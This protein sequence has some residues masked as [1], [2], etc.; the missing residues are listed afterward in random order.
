MSIMPS[1]WVI[2]AAAAPFVQAPSEPAPLPV[3]VMLPQLAMQDCDLASRQQVFV[4]RTLMTSD[5]AELKLTYAPSTDQC[6]IE[7]DAAGAAA[8]STLSDILSEDGWERLPTTESRWA[9]VDALWRKNDRLIEVNRWRKTQHED[10][11]SGA[12]F[13]TAADGLSGQQTLSTRKRQ[14]RPLA[15]ALIAAVFDL[16]P[17]LVRGRAAD[18]AELWEIEPEAILNQEVLADPTQ[19]TIDV[20][21]GEECS[22]LVSGPATPDAIQA[23]TAAAQTHGLKRDANGV[24][25]GGDI[26]IQTEARESIP[27]NWPSWARSDYASVSISVRSNQRQDAER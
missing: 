27:L 19:G 9:V 1:L 3:A 25:R 12:V 16:C 22:I 6:S 18:F 24:L 13:V 2:A 21:G 5:G 17:S 8:I 23:L 10:G 4:Y 15:D 11:P 7:L 20:R 14:L 26:E